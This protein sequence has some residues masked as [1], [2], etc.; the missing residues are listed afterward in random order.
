MDIPCE[1]EGGKKGA[2]S[3]LPIALPRCLPDCIPH[4][5]A[6]DAGGIADCGLFGLGPVGGD[7][8]Q[9]VADGMRHLHAMTHLATRVSGLVHE[10]QRERGL[11]AAFLSSDGRDF[12]EMQKERHAS[13]DGQAL[14]FSQALEQ[15]PTERFEPRLIERVAQVRGDLLNLPTWR[16]E[17][18]QLQVATQV[19]S[20]RYSALIDAL[21]GIVREMHLM[22]NGALACHLCL[23]QF[24]AGQGNGGHGAGIGGHVFLG[25]PGG[26]E[27][28]AG[29][30][31]MGGAAVPFS[32]AVPV[33]CRC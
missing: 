5:P 18:A 27:W 29:V 33:F 12:G 15:L 16:Q 31:R 20:A 13:T 30:S 26:C 2:A 23:R 21:L 22:G 17:A 4:W 9:R 19:Q 32:G 24:D 25:A 6:H 8:Q 10:I 11:S 14:L 1:R 3:S 7:D 28:S